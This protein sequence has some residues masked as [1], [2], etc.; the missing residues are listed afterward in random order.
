MPTTVYLIRHCESVANTKRMYN[1]SIDA[2]EGLSALGQ[3]Q[4]MKVGEF[5]RKKRLSAIYC[6]PFPRALQTAAEIAGHSGLKTDIVDEFRE[7]RC[8]Q[9]DG[10][11]EPEIMKAYPKAWE[12]WHKDPQNHPIPGGETLLEME[13]R[14]LPRFEALTRS[15]KGKTFAIV[16]H[17]A[18]FNVIICSLV[19]SL[20]SFRCFDTTNGTVAEIRMENVPRLQ[21]Y[22]PV[23]DGF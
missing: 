5:F 4:A 6:S 20:A 10:K 21:A 16:T 15:N 18:I 11:T 7:H 14:A 8:G 22:A 17:Y 3:K 12:G 13:A 2:D 9:W 1:C 23:G 19:S